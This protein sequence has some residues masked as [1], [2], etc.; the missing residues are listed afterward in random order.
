[1]NRPR[2]LTGGVLPAYR[3]DYARIV[4][5]SVGVVAVLV[6]ALLVVAIEVT[7]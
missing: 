5:L 3:R 1:M 2:K 6:G 4:V 7:S